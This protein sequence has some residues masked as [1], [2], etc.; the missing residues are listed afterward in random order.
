MKRRKRRLANPSEGPAWQTVCLRAAMKSNRS[1]QECGPAHR[2]CGIDAKDR[3]FAS[4]RSVG[5]I[6][7]F[8]EFCATVAIPSSVFSPA[9]RLGGS[10]P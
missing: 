4:A 5:L 9:R 3:A 2:H 10:V 6:P 8:Q 1:T 7:P